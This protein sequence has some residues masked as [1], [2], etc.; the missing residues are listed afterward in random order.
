MGKLVLVRHG[1]S[2]WNLSNR[3]TGWVD[4]PLSENGIR[5]AHLCAR[6]CEKYQ[7]SLAYTSTLSRAQ[8][9]LFSVLSQQGRT[10]VVQHPE[11]KRYGYKNGQLELDIPVRVSSVLNERYYGALQG[12]I[13]TAAVEKFGNKKVVHWRRDYHGRPP[14][15][16]SLC[17]VFLRLQPFIKGHLHR[18]LK[19]GHTALLASHGNTLRAIIKSLEGISDED[20]AFIDL[21]HAKPL[22]YEL[23][24]GKYKRIEGEYTFNRPLR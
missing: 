22:V 19:Q 4:V 1:E 16:E 13:K 24:N 14:K 9:T 23:K 8:S 10:A 20:I 17:D 21:P 18:Q 15:G 7:F 5:E 12:L 2:R 11:D 6:H 3:F